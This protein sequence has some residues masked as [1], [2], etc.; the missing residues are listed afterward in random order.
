[1]WELAQ[2]HARLL[3]AYDTWARRTG[4]FYKCR[5]A[6]VLIRSHLGLVQDHVSPYW[7][8]RGATPHSLIRRW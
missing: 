2:L 5:F 6:T 3:N 7:Y 8:I 4:G 1:M